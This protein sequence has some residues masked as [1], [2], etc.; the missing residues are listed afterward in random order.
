[1]RSDAQQTGH[2][3]TSD[4]FYENK[5]IMNMRRRAIAFPCAIGYVLHC[6][7][8][9]VNAFLLPCRAKVTHSTPTQRN[10]GHV[11]RR[12]W[13]DVRPDFVGLDHQRTLDS[14]KPALTRLQS[15]WTKCGMI[16]YVMLMCAFLPLCLLPTYLQ[17]RLGLL[18]K[19]ESEHRALQVSQKCAQ[20]LLK[21]I[22][23]MNVGE[24][25]SSAEGCSLHVAIART[26]LNYTITLGHH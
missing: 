16:A 1:M 7:S 3:K 5:H 2:G 17:T 23:F 20:T 11:R 13:T 10:V 24:S 9:H 14:T 26:H 18:S 6:K 4:L 8:I 22:P 21:W 12:G 25:C 15:T 19:K